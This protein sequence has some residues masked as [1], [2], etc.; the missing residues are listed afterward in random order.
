MYSKFELMEMTNEQ[1]MAIYETTEKESE[2]K[3]LETVLYEKNTALVISMAHRAYLKRSHFSQ[4]LTFEELLQFAS[5]G[6]IKGVRKFDGSRGNRLSTVVFQWIRASITRGLENESSVIRI[7][8]N[9]LTL[10]HSKNKNAPAELI[11]MALNYS[12]MADVNNPEVRGFASDEPQPL[13]VIGDIEQR[14]LI[15]KS[16]NDVGI[17]KVE[18]LLES[19]YR[20]SF[21]ESFNHSCD[22]TCNP[23]KVANTKLKDKV[24]E[25]IIMAFQT[26]GLT[27]QDLIDLL[28]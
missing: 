8:T 27:K 14:E 7:P 21:R 5:E 1:I 28:K 4:N 24:R 22:E 10:I 11:E 18:V 26:N 3:R 15:M 19:K 23:V 12:S 2:I 9:Q 25:K 20:A 17:H 6:F 13:E 16:V